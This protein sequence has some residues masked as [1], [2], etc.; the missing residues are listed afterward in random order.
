[1]YSS[2]TLAGA[3]A[4]VYD[5]FDVTG[6]PP[7]TPV[8]L[9]AHLTV[10]GAVWTPGCGGSGCGGRYSVDLIHGNDSLGVY[11][12]DALFNGRRDHHDEIQLPVTIVAGQPERIRIHAHGARNPG[13][14][15]LSEA[16]SV[17]TFTGLDAGVGVT[18]CKGFAD[19][20]VPV[21]A[22][23]WGRMKVIYR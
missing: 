17:L 3:H 16:L 13:G 14:S 20:T 9:F 6:V 5:D 7:G 22:T 21:R 18:S 10:D 19:G 23:T 1:M 8:Q 12:S 15:H 2:G 11:H 4:D